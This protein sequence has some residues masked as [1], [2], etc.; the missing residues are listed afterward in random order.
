MLMPEISP[1]TLSKALPLGK[2]GTKKKEK[3]Q[4][5]IEPFSLKKKDFLYGPSQYLK[6]ELKKIKAKREQLYKYATTALQGFLFASYDAVTSCAFVDVLL[7]EVIFLQ[8]PRLYTSHEKIT[9]F[10]DDGEV[11][12]ISNKF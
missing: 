9:N 7:C 1:H 5:Q 10:V 6:T 11:Q 12:F 2:T 4:R 8:I 3:N